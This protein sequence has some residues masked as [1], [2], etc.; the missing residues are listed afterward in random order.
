M[1][2]KNVRKVSISGSPKRFFTTFCVGS[3]VGVGGSYEELTAVK[4]G[5][6]NTNK[7]NEQKP[8]RKKR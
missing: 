4:E 5:G 1:K 2:G 7:R 6:D 8:S 3:L